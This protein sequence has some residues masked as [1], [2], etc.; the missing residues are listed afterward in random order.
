MR[1]P[2]FGGGE[3]GESEGGEDPEVGGVVGGRAEDHEGDAGGGE[4]A[5][6]GLGV[7]DEGDGVSV[8]EDGVHVG[9]GDL[10]ELA[11]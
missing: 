6:E 1:S 11:G 2:Q 8:V 9:A 4:G 10:G 3:A 7:A 5:E